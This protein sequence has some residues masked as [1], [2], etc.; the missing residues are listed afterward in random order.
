MMIVIV[1]FATAPENAGVVQRTL[2]AEGPD[3]RALA[4]N[5][6]YGFWSDPAQPGTWRLMH[7]WA[8]AAGF[9]AYRETPGFKA[10]GEVLFPLMVGK[11]S[12]RVFVADMVT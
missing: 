5:L 1:D 10:A 11:P 6:S 3:V 12:S 4:G 8:D 2:Q 9:A 7:E